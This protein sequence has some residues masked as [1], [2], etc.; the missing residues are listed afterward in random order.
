MWQ[1]LLP[2]VS[3]LSGSAPLNKYLM[4]NNISVIYVNGLSGSTPLK[5]WND[6]KIEAETLSGIAIDNHKHIETLPLLKYYKS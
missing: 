1:M 3:R 6:E 4:Y 5:N 2:F